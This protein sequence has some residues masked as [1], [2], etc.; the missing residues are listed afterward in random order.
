MDVN[1]FT[2]IGLFYT[3]PVLDSIS[4]NSVSELVCIIIYYYSFIKILVLNANSVDP[5]QMVH[6]DLDVLCLPVTILRVIRLKWVN[7]KKCVC[8]SK[9]ICIASLYSQLDA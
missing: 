7:G 2:F 5:D 9:Q 3:N 1:P 8:F 4:N 6:S